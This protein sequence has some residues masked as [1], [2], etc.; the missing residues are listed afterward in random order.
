MRKIKLSEEKLIKVIEAYYSLI[1]S[2]GDEEIQKAFLRMMDD[3]GDRFFEA[4]ASNK[5]EYHNCFVG[6]LAEHS[7]RVYKNL[8]ILCKQFAPDIP[9]DSITLV[10][11]LHDFGKVGTLEHPYYI[12][13]E[14]EWHR[15]NK[16]E[17]YTW[18]PELQYVGVAQRS[19][20]LAAQYGITLTEDEYKAILIHDGQYIP[21]NK[22]Y[23]HKEGW[24]ALLLHHADIIAHHTETDKWKEIQ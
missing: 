24:L 21:E 12:E 15:N 8:T 19:L 23:S 18:N 22:P 20:M 2:I 10:A 11:L 7:L 3:L 17:M 6:G 14:S 16:G 4:P 9:Q 13:Q 1:G 5:L